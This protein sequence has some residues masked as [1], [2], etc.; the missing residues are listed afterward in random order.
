M[1]LNFTWSLGLAALLLA[2]CATHRVDW[3]A[4][5]GVF[6]YDQA[7]TELGP[8]DKKATL[9]DGTMVAEWVTHYYGN[10][11]VAVG[12][13]FYGGPGSVGFIQSVGP[14]PY[15]SR[16]RL[17]FNTNNVLTKWTKN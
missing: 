15:D 3:N 12:T 6:T 17:S 14:S 1:R 4:R 11:S 2:G 10:T 8:P 7:V 16:L 5:I 9:T 13:G